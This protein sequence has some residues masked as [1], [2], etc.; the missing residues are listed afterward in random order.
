MVRKTFKSPHFMPIC[1]SDGNFVR[2]RDGIANY[3]PSLCRNRAICG[4]Q[5]YGAA[6]Q[7]IKK[8]RLR[9]LVK[10][11]QLVAIGAS[12][13][14]GMNVSARVL[15]NSPSNG[16]TVT[17]PVRLSASSSGPQ[18]I[19]MSVY[20]NNSLVAR[21]QSVSFIRSSL[22]LDPGNYTIKVVARY[23]SWSSSAVSSITVPRPPGTENTPVSAPAPAPDA[24]VA[25]QI[26]ADMQGGNEGH[27][28]GVP[29]SYDF[30]NGPVMEMGNNSS[31]WRAITAWGVLYEAAEGNP[32]TNTRVN[33][34]N[35]QTWFLQKSTGKW[36]LLQNT[37]APVGGAYYEDFSGDYSKQADIRRESDGTISAT[38]GGGFNFHFY[39]SDR[40]SIDPNDIGGIVVVL[41]ARLITAD[42]SKPDDRSKAR[43]LCGSGADYYPDLTGGWPGDSTANP[44]VAI[45]KMKYVQS[46]WRSFAMTTLSEA[47]L[48]NNPPP[49]NLSGILP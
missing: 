34:R 17:S 1:L 48:S 31:G 32:A 39:P 27:P 36:L 49:V 24:S 13:L 30:A 22:T 25:S 35:M 47:Q 20:L 41:Q 28:H 15:I 5:L 6:S 12:L 3:L 4:G 16:A 33:I 21:N 7:I 45:G 23:N 14:C 44:G 42:P 29:L 26:A 40:A 46:A 10:L 2:V 11:L 43:Y 37:S 19:S 18:P 9:T 38:A 8:G